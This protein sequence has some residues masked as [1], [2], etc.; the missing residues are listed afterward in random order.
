M[1]SRVPSPPLLHAEPTRRQTGKRVLFATLFLFLLVFVDCGCVFRGAWPAINP[2]AHCAK[3]TRIAKKNSTPR[4]LFP[5]IM[6]IN[7]KTH[8]NAYFQFVHFALTIAPLTIAP[9][10]GTKNSWIF[11]MLCASILRSSGEV[12]RC[13]LWRTETFFH[14]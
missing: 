8:N 4:T 13:L 14:R 5:A 1:S 9:Y 11:V 7:S 3:G 6:L 12:G 10:L 2:R